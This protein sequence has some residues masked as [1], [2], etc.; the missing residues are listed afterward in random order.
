MEQNI[1]VILNEYSLAAALESGNVLTVFEKCRDGYWEV[2]KE[3]PVEIDFKSPLPRL[4]SELGVLAEALGDCRI[5]AGTKISGIAY[6]TFDALGF[7]I[8]E[9]NSFSP[10][11]LDDICRE[12]AEQ[13]GKTRAPVSKSPAETAVPGKYIFDLAA[14]QEQYPEISSKKA[15]Q[16]F[17][18][19]TPFLSLTLLCRH[20]P[21]WLEND[22]SLQIETSPAD[23][24]IKAIIRKKGCGA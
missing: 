2:A 22:P 18:R 6:R 24:K 17:F 10:R 14:L 16:P 4:R 8:F 5:L 12:V 19:E 7:S 1:S 11:I 9:I 15:L 13:S 21:P 3:I 23:G 20:L